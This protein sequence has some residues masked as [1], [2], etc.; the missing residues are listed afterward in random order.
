MK[1][2]E[3]PNGHHYNADFFQVCPFCE[4]SGNAEAAAAAVTDFVQPQAER[5]AVRGENS[6]GGER[7]I[8]LAGND[9]DRGKS[10]SDI[11][12]GFD[13]KSPEGEGK[14]PAGHFLA[15][16]LVCVAGPDRGKCYEVNSGMI[17]V[18]RARNMDIVL[19]DPAVSRD[20]QLILVY[21]E[22]RSRMTARRGEAKSLCYVDD[23]PVIMDRI[24]ED[25][26]KLQMGRSMFLYVALCGDDFNW[27][28]YL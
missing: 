18:G 1:L 7:N 19:S 11:V 22:R 23:E 6:F 20:R 28:M 17:T 27:N 10:G 5:A 12:R 21:D 3:C 8:N 26:S 15:G 25:R 4:E 16:W 2:I 13:Q 9:S 24:L 14:A